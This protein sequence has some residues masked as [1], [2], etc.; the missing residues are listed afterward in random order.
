MLA[1]VVYTSVHIRIDVE[2]LIPHGVKH[3][4]WL[5]SGCRIVEIDQWL[6]IYFTSQDWEIFPD[7]VY[8]V[9]ILLFS[10]PLTPPAQERNT[11]RKLFTEFATGT[12]VQFATETFLYQV[13]QAIAKWF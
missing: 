2:I 1:Q 8:I 5:L 6:L 13:V 4:E 7:F 11:E 3:H 10:P 9:H 12:F